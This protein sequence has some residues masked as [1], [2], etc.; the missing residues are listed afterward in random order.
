MET[1]QFYS[2]LAMMNRSVVT[3]KKCQYAEFCFQQEILLIGQ[4]QK[5]FEKKVNL[6]SK[7]C[8][9]LFCLCFAATALNNK[10]NKIFYCLVIVFSVK[11][12]VVK[13]FRLYCSEIYVQKIWTRKFGLFIY[14][15]NLLN[16]ISNNC[17]LLLFTSFGRLRL[18]NDMMYVK[19]NT[20]ITALVLMCTA[21]VHTT[22]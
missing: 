7:C 13:C 16:W 5:T 18:G 4:F 12:I 9:H 14:D 15:R 3:E 6:I 20:T 10:N 17:K 19:V 22:G 1:I 21:R 8:D 11:K 2:N